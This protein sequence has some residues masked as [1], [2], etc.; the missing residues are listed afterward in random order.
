MCYSFHSVSHSLY[1]NF[2]FNFIFTDG[3]EMVKD[4]DVVHIHPQPEYT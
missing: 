2:D 1:D 4:T 3:Y